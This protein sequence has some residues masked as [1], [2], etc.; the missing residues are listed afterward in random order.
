MNFFDHLH[1]FFH[2]HDALEDIA[3]TGFFVSVISYVMFWGVE[4]M[5]PGFVSRHFSVHIFFLIAIVFGSVW[6]DRM[7]DYQNHP[8][9]QRIAV[10]LFGIVLFVLTWNLGEGL[11]AS[12]I[13]VSLIAFLVPVVVLKLIAR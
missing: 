9:L 8:V 4:V 10:L 12:R 6:N 2:P 3:K 7:H 13:V 1:N 11:A 5:R